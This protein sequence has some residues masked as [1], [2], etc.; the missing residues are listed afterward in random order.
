MGVFCCTN[1]H[2]S[3]V[4]CVLWHA[5]MYGW[6]CA[7]VYVCTMCSKIAVAIITCAAMRLTFHAS[8]IV[9]FMQVSFVDAITQWHDFVA[10]FATTST[11]IVLVG[12]KSDADIARQVDGERAA[13]SAQSLQWHHCEV[14]SLTGAGLDGLMQYVGALTTPR[15]E[16]MPSVTLA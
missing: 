6:M 10:R 11:P 5:I 4:C 16:T 15:S 13:L 2:L 3:Y 9:D 12:T 8:P 1:P 7:C 14:S